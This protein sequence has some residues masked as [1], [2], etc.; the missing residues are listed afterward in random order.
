M[1]LRY[2]ASAKAAQEL[3]VAVQALGVREPDDFNEAFAEMDR[4]TPDAILMVSDSLTLLNR[5]RVID[6]AAAHRLPAIYEADSIVH[7]GGLMSY[8]ADQR[9]SF[10]RAAALA[11]RIFKGAKPASLPFEEPTR[12]LF[13]INLKTAKAMNFTVPNTLAALA[14]EII[15]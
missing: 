7:D 13:V 11:D 5:K 3:G 6:Y 8:G 10:N 2:Q 4:E 15:E 14:D 12:Y 9:E 1:S